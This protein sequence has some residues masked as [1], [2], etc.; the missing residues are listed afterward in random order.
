MIDLRDL[1]LI[2]ADTRNHDLALRALRLSG[3]ACR[4]GRALFFTDREYTEPG[5]EIVRVAPLRSAADYSRLLMKDLLEHIH[6]PYALVVQWDGYVLHPEAWSEDFRN[7]DYLGARWPWMP[8]GSEIGNGGFSL[9]SRK[10]LE[11]LADPEISEFAIEDVAIGQTYRPLLESRHGIRYAPAAVADRF[12][13]ETTAPSRPTF[14]FHALYNFWL[15]LPDA[16]L[17]EILAGLADANTET[18]QLRV[19]GVNYLCAGRHE[20]AALTFQRILQVRPGDAEVAR[21]LRF[22]E[23]AL[24][25]PLAGR[26][27]PCPCGSGRRFKGCHGALTPA[28]AQTAVAAPTPAPAPVPKQPRLPDFREALRLHEIGD[29]DAAESIYRE[30]LRLKPDNPIPM[31][32]LGVAA[33]QKKDLDT[34]IPLL[35]RA[36]ALV[37]GEANFHNN[38]GLALV[39]AQRIEEA[40]PCYERALAIDPGSTAAW[41][42]L[43]LARQALLDIDG[44]IVAFETAIRLQPEFDR[45]HWN[46][47]YAYLLAG[48]Y[49]E[50]WREYEWRLQI[51]DLAGGL[52]PV[53]GPAW[54]GEIRPGMR[55]L[56]HAEQ[57]L[58]DTIQFARFVPR[59]VAAGASVILEC[60]PVLH[61]VLS[62]LGPG[63]HLHA[64]GTARPEYECHLALPSLPGMLGIEAAAVPARQGFLSAAPELIESWRDRFS[65]MGGSL[66]VGITWGGN[67]ANPY[68]QRRSCALRDLELIASMPGVR[69]V[70][71]QTGP[72]RAEL[73]HLPPQI[74]PID[75]AEDLT[76]TAAQI[77]ALDLIIS[78]DTAIAHLAGALGKETWILLPF[79]P[80][81]RWLTEREDSPWYASARLFRQAHRG[82]WVEPVQ[83]MADALALRLRQD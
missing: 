58:G 1:T 66:R 42:N 40:L 9:R 56:L 52:P 55:L 50:G 48:R 64:A 15:T 71:L 5:V 6:T 35:A 12:S 79:S 61:G 67:P 30:L 2:C 32:F 25:A 57:G 68:D 78:V 26:N 72:R 16:Q 27:D 21:L 47:A 82:R 3:Q 62:T 65:A 70:S 60:P 80:D 34:A 14:G 28:S 7:Y 19:L 43:G 31:H 8:Q 39:E 11:A 69:L 75:C 4:F 10:L 76:T 37:P 74:R 41:S 45:A 29:V 13:F 38:L 18:P 22:A 33:M 24:N 49:A 51:K 54:Q 77:M 17:P 59:L 53:P 81:W 73:E 63:V 46:L 44:A 20:P 83:A 36:A 23:N